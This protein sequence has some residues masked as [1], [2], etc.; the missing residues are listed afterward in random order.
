MSGPPCGAET[1]RLLRAEGRVAV[2]LEAGGPPED[3]LAVSIRTATAAGPRLSGQERA[4]LLGYASGL[5]L[6][7]A[8]RR[9]GIRPATAKK[10]LE[11]VKQKYADCGRNAY[12]KLDLASRA[13]EDGLIG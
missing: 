6:T 4:V 11:R 8:A 12:T 2:P 5:T 7:A 13:R 10:Y 1:V 9:A 3:R